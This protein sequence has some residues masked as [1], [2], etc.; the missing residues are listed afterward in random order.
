M[1]RRQRN[2]QIKMKNKKLVKRYPFLITKNFE[3]KIPKNYDFTFTK[4]DYLPNGWRVGFGEFLLEDLRNACLKTNYLNK[5]QILELKEKFGSMR[6]YIN[7]APQEINDIIRKYEFISEYICMFCGSPHAFNVSNGGWYMPICEKCWNKRNEMR[8]KGGYKEIPWK[9]MIDE[10]WKELPNEYRYT[11]FSKN[12][13]TTT[14]VDISDTVEKI[15]N[16]YKKR[17][18][19]NE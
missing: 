6:M 8:R 12:G 7:G 15:K 9:E 18:L 3:G 19:K 2:K 4:Y 16:K 5:L 17:R 1:N 13:N 10:K 14:T 11:T